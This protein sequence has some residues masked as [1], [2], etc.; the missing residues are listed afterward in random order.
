MQQNILTA[1][2][3][4]DFWQKLGHYVGLSGKPK[5]SAMTDFESL[6]KFIE[7]RASHVS[8]TALYGYMKTRAGTR[9]PEMFEDPGM[10][11]SINI[12]KWQVWM[13]C[14]SDLTVYL[15]ALITQRSVHSAEDVSKMMGQLA[16]EIVA[17]T[18]SPEDAGDNFEEARQSYIQR[19]RDSLL[20]RIADDETAFSQSPAA[21]VKWSPIADELKVR[22]VEIVENSMR[23]RWI[24]VRRSARELLDGDSIMSNYLSA[25]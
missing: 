18:G 24:E 13:S 5:R 21:L 16:E 4:K 15:G 9:F 14:V 6:K 1:L 23:F 20:D 11:M 3:S 2:I 12:A 25:D 22:D 7:S 8:Q 10:L 19:V 17:G